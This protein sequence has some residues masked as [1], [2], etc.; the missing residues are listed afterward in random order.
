VFSGV[1][2]ND[3]KNQNP[4]T[5]PSTVISRSI[6]NPVNQRLTGFKLLT[7]GLDGTE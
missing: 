3:L 4:S 7:G 6:K 5:V 2:E 1:S